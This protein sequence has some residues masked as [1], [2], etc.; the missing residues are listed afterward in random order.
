MKH[1]MT[2]SRGEIFMAVGDCNGAIFTCF[3]NASPDVDQS[4]SLAVRTAIFLE[5]FWQEEKE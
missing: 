3:H 1:L 2:L 5:H 4:P